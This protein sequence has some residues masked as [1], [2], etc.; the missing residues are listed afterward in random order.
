MGSSNMICDLLSNCFTSTY[1]KGPYEFVIG[2]FSNWDYFLFS[3]VLSV[4]VSDVSGCG[5]SSV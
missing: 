4:V 2:T 5:L 3:V 1:L